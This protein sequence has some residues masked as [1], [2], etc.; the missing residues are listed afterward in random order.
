MNFRVEWLPDAERSNDQPVGLPKR[1]LFPHCSQAVSLTY[2]KVARAQTDVDDAAGADDVEAEGLG[3]GDDFGAVAAGV[4]PDFF[5]APPLDFLQQPQNDLRRQ[6]DADPVEVL[7][8][9]RHQIRVSLQAFDR[10]GVR[11]DREDVVSLLQVCADRFIAVLAAIAAGSEDGDGGFGHAVSFG[12]AE[13]AVNARLTA[14]S[15]GES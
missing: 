5:G 4:E 3:T 9:D 1:I 2:L 15:T 13:A 11:V 7:D 8:R 14:G 12:G 6:V 10:R